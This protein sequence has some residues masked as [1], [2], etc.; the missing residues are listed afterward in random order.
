VQEVFYI[1]TGEFVPNIHVN[2]A[3]FPDEVANVA[4]LRPSL[5]A[6]DV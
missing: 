6:E 4:P 2:I 5:P 3:P 1:Q